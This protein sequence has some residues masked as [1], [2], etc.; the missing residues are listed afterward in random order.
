METGVAD[1]Q[2]AQ[3]SDTGK[4]PRAGPV[5][6]VDGNSSHRTTWLSKCTSSSSRLQPPSKGQMPGRGRGRGGYKVGRGRGR[7]STT[8]RPAAPTRRAF[9]PPTKMAKICDT[10]SNGQSQEDG[11]I[12]SVDEDGNTIYVSDGEEDDAKEME[13]QPSTRKLTSKVWLEMEKV[14]INGEWKAKCYWCHRILTTGSRS[15][16][17]HLGVH[18]KICTQKKLKTKRGKTLSRSSLKVSANDGGKVSMESYAFDQEYARAELG[19]MLVF[20]DYPLSMVDHIGFRRFVA[21]LQ[22]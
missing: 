21:G 12:E 18:L 4:L 13:I 15:G 3:Q 17:K 11:P 16:T 5:D 19:N 22:P 14:R 9:A 2:E 10:S 6:G 1:I 8:K 20:R 7:G